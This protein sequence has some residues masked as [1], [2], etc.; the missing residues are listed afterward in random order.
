MPVSSCLLARTS[1]FF[2]NC[3]LLILIMVSTNS[4]IVLTKQILFPVS[5]KS[6]CTSWMK[7]LENR[8]PQQEYGSSLKIDFPPN[9]KNVST[10]GNETLAKKYDPVD[11][12]IALT[13][14]S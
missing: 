6:V 11:G 14:S 5:R 12:K 9:K 3:L 7:V 13:R 10:S 2:E 4:N 1:S 8:F